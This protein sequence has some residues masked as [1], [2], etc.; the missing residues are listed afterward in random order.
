M[1]LDVVDVV[2]VGIAVAVAVAY[3]VARYL[4]IGY[5]V[6]RLSKG[7]SSCTPRQNPFA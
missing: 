5:L 6:G 2:V 1:M 7:F 4:W 3:L